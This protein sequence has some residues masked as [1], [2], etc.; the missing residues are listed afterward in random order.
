MI[1]LPCDQHPILK[2]DAAPA[3]NDDRASQP[4]A[5]A[6]RGLHSRTLGVITELFPPA[7]AIDVLDV[8]AGRGALSYQLKNAGYRVSACDLFP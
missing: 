2:H 6:A 5:L 8:G 3:V 7:G 1:S 4:E